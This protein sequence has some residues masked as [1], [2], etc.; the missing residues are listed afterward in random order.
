MKKWIINRNIL[1]ENGVT[2]KT[3]TR[4]MNDDHQILNVVLSSAIRDSSVILFED[5][6][7]EVLMQE[8]AVHEVSGFVYR[9]L[10]SQ[11]NFN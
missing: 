1:N 10:K 4:S 5:V 9:A 11:L 2:S 7:V 3:R 8:A 6:D